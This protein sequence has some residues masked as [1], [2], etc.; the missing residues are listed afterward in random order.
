MSIITS[1][2]DTDFYKF[3]MGQ[4]VF[5]RFPDVD[6]EY[7][8]RCRSESIDLLPYIDQIK[9]EISNLCSLRCTTEELDYLSNIRFM[10]KS[11]IEFLRVLQ[12]NEDFIKK[13]LRRNLES[14]RQGF[15]IR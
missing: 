3:T 4:I 13:T 2:F 7:E 1:L 14:F 12:L 6:I 15:W 11:F 10:K 8:F 9:E 5:H